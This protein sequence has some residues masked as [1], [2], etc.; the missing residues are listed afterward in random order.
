MNCS[1]CLGWHTAHGHM[2]TA[3]FALIWLDFHNFKGVSVNLETTKDE[4]YLPMAN[5]H[6]I[7]ERHSRYSL[8][9]LGAA[10]LSKGKLD[11]QKRY[12]WMNRNSDDKT[13]MDSCILFPSVYSTSDHRPTL[14]WHYLS[15]IY[16]SFVVATFSDKPD[17]EWQSKLWLATLLISQPVSVKPSTLVPL[18]VYECKLL[19]ES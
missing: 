3:C 19:M 6:Q 5:I 12:F 2:H 9:H 15:F 14:L 4:L 7:P 16:R 1:P 17:P 11:I 10:K 8:W 18:P 13:Y